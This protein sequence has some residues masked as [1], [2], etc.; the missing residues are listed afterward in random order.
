MGTE[1]SIEEYFKALDTEVEKAYRV[2]VEAKKRNL[3]P[4]PIPESPN[5]KDVAARVEAIVGPEG[6]SSRIR[7][8]E[9]T[10]DREAV[11]FQIAKEIA[12][13]RYGVEDVSTLAEQALRTSL[14]IV[15]EGIVAAPIEGISKVC[16]KQNPD[17][18]QYLAV[19]YAGPIRSAGGTAQALSI[20]LADH[21]RTSLDL[22]PY[23][24]TEEEIER[25]KEEV[26]LYD[27][28]AKLQYLPSPEEIET[29]LRRIPVEVTG[30]PTV[31]TEVMGYRD[32]PRIETNQLRGGAILVIAEGLLQKA[33]KLY[34][35]AQKLGIDGW[36][37]LQQI[38]RPV[39]KKRSVLDEPRQPLDENKGYLQDLVAGRPV[40]A[41]PSKPGG[42]RLR[43][44]RSR[45]TGLAAVAL[46]PATL[47]LLDSFIVTGTQLKLERPGKA[48]IITPCATIEGP[49]VLLQDG[50][51]HRVETTTKAE[52][53]KGKV[54]RILFVGD[55]LISYG[56]FFQNNHP[57]PPSPYVEEWWALELQE[58]IREKRFSPKKHG[59]T[60]L[61]YL[62]S[63][64]P[65]ISNAR[66]AQLIGQPHKH[67][68]THQEALII[69]HTLGMPLHPKY[70]LAWENITIEELKH[71]LF[72]IKQIAP[73]QD[74]YSLPYSKKTKNILERLLLPHHL[75]HEKIHIPKM[76][77]EPLLAYLAMKK[78]HYKSMDEIEK[79]ISKESSLDICALLSKIA[80][81][82]VY[83]H[84]PFSIGARMGRPEKAKP[85]EM[86][87]PPHVLYPIGHAGGM[88]RSIPK[89][90]EKPS[91][92]VEM[93]QRLCPE[94]G[95]LTTHPN[96]PSCNHPTRLT[97][98][99][100]KCGKPTPL[101][102]DRCP[103]C[104]SLTSTTC[105]TTF[106]LGEELEKAYKN[107]GESKVPEIKGIIGMISKHKIPE[108]LEKGILRAKYQLPVYR[109]GTTRF[110]TIDAPLTHFR[111][112]EIG[113]SLEKLKKLG[114][115]HDKDGK[116][117]KDPEQLVELKPQD[118]II[119]EA[120]AE[121]LVRVA[122][123]IDDLL[124]KFYKTNPYYS[125]FK[126]KDLV[127]HLVVGLAP[128]T[129]AGVVGRIIG[130]TPAKVLYAHPYF[131]AAKRRNC[132]GDEDSIQLLMDTLLNF[133]KYYLP[134]R[135]GGEMDAPL[136]IISRIDPREVDSEAHNIDIQKNYPLAFY[137]KTLNYPHP[138][139]I[140]IEQVR[141]RLGTPQQYFN[142]GFT[143]DTPNIAEGP[144]QSTY[145]KL[146]TMKEKVD[147]QLALAEKILAVD[148][149][150][151]AERLITR[152]FLKDLQGNL[153]KFA[154]QQ[155]RC[156]K[157]NTKYRRP[158]LSGACRRC[159]GNLILTVPRGTVDKYL[160]ITKELASRYP[161]T[162]YTRQRIEIIQQAIDSLF[163]DDTKKQTSLSQFV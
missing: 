144:H 104:N 109:D 138:G 145:T 57:L 63:P 140:K 133:S 137:R 44:G 148:A 96:C 135:R 146:A 12:R 106:N 127:G 102:T 100:P 120:A 50:S 116:P 48:A 35:I 131:H 23:R 84:T 61:S 79:I 29:A 94:C 6:V 72:T 70:A 95:N 153:S 13:G 5:A 77:A 7:E 71:L 107:L 19:Y 105:K 58:K 142:L 41:H 25:F 162:T 54:K 51:V 47:I 110:D 163:Q 136:I 9:A 149:A 75:D 141:H 121:F 27:D 81:F 17:K 108:P 39:G 82:P 30:D 118:L 111:P 86:S 88:T 161:L 98:Y 158:P 37:W 101:K 10:M 130:T 152:H 103:T 28:V 33:P 38:R 62:E 26:E 113:T 155:F 21:I 156:A 22:S 14:A 67:K 8:L 66:L 34:K 160:E 69:S 53:I 49:T 99:C 20:L 4:M 112:A 139:E 68:P 55:I 59:N 85:R 124:T 56:D 126:P 36:E 159:N 24:P 114:Y 15:T 129:S 89:A 60:L 46:H 132:D 143:H 45:A 52:E 16:V 11:A 128:H 91:I 42:F 151:V 122:K 150:D 154:K 31:R 80:G 115:T 125:I 87:P 40:L 2:A 65:G 119:P 43:Y 90:A 32:L 134:D 93:A 73:H 64:V 78:P 18:T 74:T 123:F 97:K 147:A 157:C 117:L 1:T 76:Y 3:D 92:S 83:P